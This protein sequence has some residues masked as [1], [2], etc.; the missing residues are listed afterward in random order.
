MTTSNRDKDLNFITFNLRQRRAVKLTYRI[1][2]AL[3]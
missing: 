2:T 3:I 1:I